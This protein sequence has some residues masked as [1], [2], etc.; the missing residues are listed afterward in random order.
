VGGVIE[1]RKGE[2]QDA[3]SVPMGGR[4]HGYRIMSRAERRSCV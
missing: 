3:D 1:L 4:Q 2:E